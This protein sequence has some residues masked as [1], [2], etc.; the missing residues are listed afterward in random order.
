[1]TRPR[2]RRCGLCGHQPACG[3]AS[4]WNNDRQV[5]LCHADDHSCYH[6]WTVY[7]ERP[8]ERVIIARRQ[9]GTGLMCR[10]NCGHEVE[11]LDLDASSLCQECAT[12]LYRAHPEAFVKENPN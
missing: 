1:M 9:P 7:K 11:L 12:D 4:V 6:R 5:F 3:S 2:N 10:N 8:M